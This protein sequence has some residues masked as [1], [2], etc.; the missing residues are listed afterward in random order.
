MKPIAVITHIDR[1]DV[2]LFDEVA[3]ERGHTPRIVR[4]YR[5]D[6]LPGLDQVAAVVIMGGPQ[7]AYHDHPY[8]NAERRYLAEAVQAA[9]PVFAICLGAQVLAGALGG[10]AEPGDTGLEAGVI[11]VRPA[12]GA[13]GEVAGEFFSFHSDSMTPPAGAGLLAGSDRYLQAWTAGSALAVQFHPEITLAGVDKVLAVEGEKLQRF[14]V[15]VAVMR[16]DAERYFRGGAADSRA[17]LHHWFDRLGA[18]H[19][20]Q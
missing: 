7:S 8:L 16:R 1:T 3:R 5:G 15:D 9:V 6:P 19:T 18:E 20:H 4:P 12:R 11:K 2:G 10:S 17:L 14:G 13:G